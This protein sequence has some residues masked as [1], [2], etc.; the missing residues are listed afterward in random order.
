MIIFFARSKCPI[1][2]LNPSCTAFFQYPKQFKCE[3]C[4]LRL[5]RKL[6]ARCSQ[7]RQDGEDHFW[8]SEALSDIHQPFR[9]GVCHNLTFGIRTCRCRPEERV[10]RAAFLTPVI[11]RE[12]SKYISVYI[13]GLITKTYFILPYFLHICSSVVQCDFLFREAQFKFD[14]CV[15]P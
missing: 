4:R 3:S 11:F 2:K 9:P 1:S 6:T 14:S 10:F 13:T 8:W 12:M 15:F 5:V 7:V